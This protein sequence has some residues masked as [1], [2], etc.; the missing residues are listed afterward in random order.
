MRLDSGG[1]GRKGRDRQEFPSGR[2]ARQ[3]ECVDPQFGLDGE[4]AEGLTFT[5]VFAPIT[6]PALAFQLVQERGLIYPV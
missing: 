4:G 6:R 5:V 2:G 3:A 1:N